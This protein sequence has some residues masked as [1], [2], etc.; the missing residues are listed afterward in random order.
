MDEVFIIIIGGNTSQTI[1]DV[2]SAAVQI[3]S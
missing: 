2:L 3:W 1:R